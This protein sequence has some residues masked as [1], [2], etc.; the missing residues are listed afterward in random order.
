MVYTFARLLECRQFVTFNQQS[1]IKALLSEVH[2]LILIYLTIPVTTATAEQSF[3]ALKRIK[4]YLRNSMTQQRLNHCF[5]LHIHRQKTDSLENLFKGMK[6]DKHSL[7][8]TIIK[9]HINSLYVHIYIWL[10]R[11]NEIKFGLSFLMHLGPPPQSKIGSYS[12]AYVL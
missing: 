1:S 6:E 8:T 3:S 5:I 12:T 9:F 7:A 2:K 11:T 4:T 10:L